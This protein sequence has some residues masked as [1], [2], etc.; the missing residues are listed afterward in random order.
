MRQGHGPSSTMG[1]APKAFS[2]FVFFAATLLVGDIGPIVRRLRH[3]CMPLRKGTMYMENGDCA[4]SPELSLSD[5][6]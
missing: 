3:Q 5:S 4:Y 6:G 2:L 1:S